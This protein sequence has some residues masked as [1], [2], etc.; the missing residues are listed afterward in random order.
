MTNKN[1]CPKCGQ[2]YDAEMPKCPLCGA[3]SPAQPSEQLTDAPRR[4]GGRYLSA[5]D[6][7]ALKREE[8]E[9]LRAEEGRYRRMKQRGETDAPEETDN[10]R[11]PAG[12]LVASILILAA[13][14]LVGGSFLL[15]KT[16]VLHIGLYD[17]LSG[18]TTEPSSVSVPT[19]T[20]IDTANGTETTLSTQQ[21]TEPTAETEET[22]PKVMLPFDFDPD[23][24]VLTLVNESNPIPDDFPVDDM[25]TLGTGALINRL[26]MDA[27]QN[28]VSDCRLAKHYPG[29]YEGYDETAKD[30]SEYRTGLAMDIF[31]ENDQARDVKTQSESET[32]QWLWEHCWEYGFIVRYPEGKE[33]ITGHDYEPWHFRYVG[34]DVAEY[35]HEEELCFEEMAELLRQAEQ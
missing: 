2:I 17:R 27:L 5:D 3:V 12:F 13:A 25:A 21:S 28:M 24:P 35:M 6:K 31:P 26:C 33:D 29:V 16:N 22:Q 7:K 15:W 34:K 19:D 20:V 18:R 8:E 30:T 4:G 14:L 32:L 9:F 10:P 1:V 11:I 23:D